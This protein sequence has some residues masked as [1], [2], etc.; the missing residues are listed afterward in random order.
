MR[1]KGEVSFMPES[2]DSKDSFNSS[3]RS[4]VSAR[5]LVSLTTD[6]LAVVLRFS[7]SSNFD[8]I[9]TIKERERRETEGER[10]RDRE[11][12]RDRETDR[13]TERQTEGDRETE[14]QRERERERD[15]ERETER[16]RE[17]NVQAGGKSDEASE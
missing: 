10:D 6:S 12:E 8:L 15:R 9:F 4:V 7:R 5:S 13:E 11:T 2:L 17:G 16:Q 14:R 1:T 3:N